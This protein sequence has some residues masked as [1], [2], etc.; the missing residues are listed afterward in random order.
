M[1]YHYEPPTVA[2]AGVEPGTAL[3]EARLSEV[4]GFY[5]G[6][7]YNRRCI[8]QCGSPVNVGK[9]TCGNGH[10]IS[11]HAECTAVDV[12][13]RDPAVHAKVIE[14]ALSDAGAAWQIQEIISG[15][16]PISLGRWTPDKGWLPYQGVSDHVDHVHLSQTHEA[17]AW[18]TAPQEDDMAGKYRLVQLHGWYDTLLIAPSG[19]VIVPKP[20]GPGLQALCDDGW[21]DNGHKGDGTSW[22]DFIFVFRDRDEWDLITANAPTTAQDPGVADPIP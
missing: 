2:G 4:V 16:S 18:T 21:V 8:Q 11:H 7:S 14:W 22:G 1:S 15:Y 9:P 19:L 5:V 10:P 17:A 12:M 6:G 13:T 3:L 20:G